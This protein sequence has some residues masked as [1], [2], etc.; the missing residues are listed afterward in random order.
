[1]EEA[2]QE[3]RPRAF[4][5]F[6]FFLSHDISSSFH[7]AS[8]QQVRIATCPTPLEGAKLCPE[9]VVELECAA[10][11]VFAD[12]VR[13]FLGDQLYVVEHLVLG[14]FSARIVLEPG[15]EIRTIPGI[16]VTLESSYVYQGQ[17]VSFV[18]KLTANLTQF[19]SVEILT[20]SCGGSLAYRSNNISLNF[21]IRSNNNYS[22]TS[23]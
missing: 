10:N 23:E 2:Y 11:N 14:N 19:N 17:P 1:M 3:G 6:F 16:V 18:S 8:C 7:A 22:R 5:F 20:F 12:D 15:S 13:W 4:H 21:T 9:D